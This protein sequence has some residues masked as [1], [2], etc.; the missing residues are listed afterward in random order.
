MGRDLWRL[1]GPTP[2]Q[3]KDTGQGAQGHFQKNMSGQVNFTE[4][5]NGL[6]WKGR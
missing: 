1:A 5:Q 3:D 4:S 2:A 6:G